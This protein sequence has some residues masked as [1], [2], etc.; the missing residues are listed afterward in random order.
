MVFIF[1]LLAIASHL[2]LLFWSAEL[3]LNQ[4]IRKEPELQSGAFNQPSL[5][6]DMV[7]SVGV[8]PNIITLKGLCPNR[9]DDDSVWLRERDSNS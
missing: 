7:K 8:E 2:L 3:D 4:R 5:P 1:V 6:A 9:L